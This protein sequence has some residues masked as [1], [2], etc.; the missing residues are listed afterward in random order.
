LGDPLIVLNRKINWESFREIL[1]EIRPEN[2]P[3]NEKNAGRKPYDAVMMFKILI[4][5]RYYS[6]L[7]DQMEFQLKDR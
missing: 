5:Q 4:L 7:D 3:D 6:L 2:N 1:E